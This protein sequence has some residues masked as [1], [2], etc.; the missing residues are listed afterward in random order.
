MRI[1]LSTAIL[2]CVAA[3]LLLLSLG[4][5]A[6]ATEPPAPAGYQLELSDEGARLW[7]HASKGEDRLTVKVH[8]AD[9]G[10]PTCEHH[11]LRLEV[12]TPGSPATQTWGAALC[13]LLAEDPDALRPGS[14]VRAPPQQP[15]VAPSVA[16]RE[17]RSL[18]WSIPTPRIDELPGWP[19]NWYLQPLHVLA[20]AWLLLLPWVLPRAGA[21]WAATGF[22]VAVRLMFGEWALMGAGYPQQRYLSAT[23]TMGDGGLYGAA[24][25]ALMSVPWLASGGAPDAQHVT[26]VVLSSLA[27]PVLYDL[28]RRIQDEDAARVAAWLL[29]ASPF[30]IALPGAGTMFG[31]ASTLAIAALAGAVGERRRDLV[32]SLLSL[33]L[34]ANLRPYM[35]LFCG[36]VVLWFVRRRLWGAALLGVVAVTAR[37]AEILWLNPPESS[38]WSFNTM[39]YGGVT[40]AGEGAS[41]TILD[42]WR[43]PVAATALAVLAIRDLGGLHARLL[44]AS[45]ASLVVPYLLFW[46]ASDVARFSLPGTTLLFGLAAIGFVHRE[47]LGAWALGLV[48]TTMLAARPAP[49]ETSWSAEHRALLHARSLVEPATQVWMG[50]VLQHPQRIA[51][52]ATA[53]LGP[54]WKVWTPDAAPK[55]GDLWWK[56]RMS[57]WDGA[58]SPCLQP[59]PIAS[60][61]VPQESSNVEPPPRHGT[62]V[63]LYRCRVWRGH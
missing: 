57:G 36:V 12:M 22:A 2:R 25:S 49:V 18:A 28:V 10:E 62:E 26:S 8:T 59:E 24:W 4:T 5:A 32:L 58:M 50:P 15:Y 42:P 44:A 39:A 48:L 3:V 56:T 31:L 17:S 11:G 13:A 52:W 55:P 16:P 30:A 47:R 41:L 9:A 53:K 40:L 14:R 1:A 46:R 7:L 37:V 21:V 51:R 34:L 33:A 61:V 43:V 27:V 38:V 54:A 35:L 20:L 63:G 23:G 19:P 45:W 6:D 60:A 29:A